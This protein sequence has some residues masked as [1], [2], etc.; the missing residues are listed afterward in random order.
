MFGFG[1]KA[2]GKITLTS[3]GIELLKTGDEKQ[4]KQ[5]LS[6]F[7]NAFNS[8]AEDA[9]GLSGGSLNSILDPDD[10]ETD[11]AYGIRLLGS[12]TKPADPAAA[13]KIFN[14]MI[15]GKYPGIELATHQ[16]N[17]MTQQTNEM[18]GFGMPKTNVSNNTLMVQGD[19]KAGNKVMAA[20]QKANPQLAAQ[21]KHAGSTGPDGPQYYGIQFATPQLAAQAA[22]ALGQVNENTALTG[23]Y[24]HSGKLQAVKG[25][26]Q[27]MM[28][29]IKF[30]AGITK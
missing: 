27:D 24:G 21:G 20:L 16:G 25:L 8:A 29:R 19:Q 10:Y 4:D 13:K 22:Q 1:K 5:N 28:D 26:D 18:F 11:A 3:K 12:R 7:Y 2:A 14:Q 9:L 15:H 6:S 23:Q 17:D 30:L